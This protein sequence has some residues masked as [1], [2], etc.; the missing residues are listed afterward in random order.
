VSFFPPLLP[1][2]SFFFS[3]YYL[4]DEKVDISFPPFS[5]PSL[6]LG[7]AGRRSGLQTLAYFFPP[8]SFFSRF[9]FPFLFPPGRN[10]AP[11]RNDGSVNVFPPFFFFFWIPFPFQN[12]AGSK[13]EKCDQRHHLF[14]FS[15]LVSFSSF[16]LPGHPGERHG[17]DE[18]GEP[19]ARQLS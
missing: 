11:E 4:G 9:S 8:P 15:P 12:S 5:S 18:K 6:G 13:D 14:P 1:L 7:A 19:K 2:P 3:F 17:A 10:F 16:H